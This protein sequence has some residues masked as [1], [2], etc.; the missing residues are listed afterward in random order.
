MQMKQNLHEPHFGLNGLNGL[1]GLLQ[2]KLQEFL[3]LLLL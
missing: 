1:N 2:R 3:L